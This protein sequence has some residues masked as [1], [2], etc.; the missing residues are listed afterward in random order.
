MLRPSTLMFEVMIV[1]KLRSLNILL[2]GKS[3]FSRWKCEPFPPLDIEI[4]QKSLKKFIFSKV[5]GNQ[6]L[7][8]VDQT[9][10]VMNCQ[11]S[12]HLGS[13]TGNGCKL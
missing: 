10:Q 12:K 6:K 3:Y 5:V 4:R 7:T 11:V 8:P 13:L 9:V 2:T 1:P